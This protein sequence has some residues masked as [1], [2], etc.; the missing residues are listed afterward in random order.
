[1]ASFLLPAELSRQHPSACMSPVRRLAVMPQSRIAVRMEAKRT[2]SVEIPSHQS[3]TAIAAK[4]SRGRPKRNQGSPKRALDNLQRTVEELERRN[5]ELTA[6]IRRRDQFLAMLSHE[7]RNP[8]A[9]VLTAAQVIGRAANDSESVAQAREVIERQARQAARLLDDL[10]DVGRMTE[11]KMAL[12]K[13]LVDLGPL[14]ND[15]LNAARPLIEA[16]RHRLRLDLPQQPIAVHGDPARL[17]QVIENLL[18][19]AAKYTPPGGEIR[20]CLARDGD[21]AT[22]EVGDSGIGIAKEHLESIFGLFTQLDS[23]LDRSERGLGVGLSMVQMLVKMHGG[24]VWAES[25]GPGR[26][27]RFI[28]RLPAV[29]EHPDSEK[30][31]EPDGAAKPV[32]VLIVEDIADSRKILRRLLSL[33]GHDVREAADGQS[34]L[35]AL[36]SR[37]PDVALVD[38]GLPGMDG[39]QV[40]R[41]ARQSPACQHVRLVALTGYG[42]AQD[43][44][45]VLAAGFDEHL[46]KPVNPA[47]LAR[48]LRPRE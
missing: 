27:S 45:A 6:G 14:L 41:A 47:D 24:K 28:V 10:L 12:D 13:S 29:K 21:T 44:K 42:R 1:L 25:D 17:L 19:N 39:Y 35:A 38:V 32:S 31:G 18:T 4:P 7:L 15:A 36:L 11:G 3:P 46:V 40:A 20:L 5:A 16:R 34:G 48:V 26:G 23:S 33:D 2:D 43:H 30:D 22:L 37:P 9:A 8:L